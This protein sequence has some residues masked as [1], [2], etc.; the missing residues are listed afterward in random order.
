MSNKRI[1]E[2]KNT[3]SNLIESDEKRNEAINELGKLA[4]ENEDAFNALFKLADEPIFDND[5]KQIISIIMKLVGE[6]IIKHKKREEEKKVAS[7][8]LILRIIVINL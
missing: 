5:K 7:F 3:I 2:L 8:F 6:K 1:T 4:E